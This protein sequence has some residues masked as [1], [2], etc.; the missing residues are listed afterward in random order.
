[1][2]EHETFT[3]APLNVDESAVRLTINNGP[4]N[5]VDVALLLDLHSF[6]IDLS[7]S[8][9]APK[10]V[11]IASD[12]PNFWINHLDLHI[13]SKQDPLPEGQDSGQALYHLGTITQL[14]GTL[15]SILVAEVNG[16]A[17][18]GGNE[19]AMNM[20]MQFAGPNAL[21]GVVEVGGGLIHVG[22]L[23]QLTRLIGAGHAAEYMLSATGVEAETA[24]TIGWVHTSFRTGE[25]L[26]QYVNTLALKRC[27]LSS[28]CFEIY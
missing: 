1:M 6:L 27:N 4:T 16:R 28:R 25:G 13:A 26:R 12:I 8:P 24:A 2:T 22:A 18:A 19:F 17:I 3:L 14:F 11:V 21:F 10:V 9:T 5:L 7:S 20:D 15:S 23:Q